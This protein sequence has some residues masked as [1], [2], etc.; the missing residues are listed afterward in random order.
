VPRGTFAHWIRND[1]RAWN[2]PRGTLAGRR[3]CDLGPGGEFTLQCLIGQVRQREAVHA[4]PSTGAGWSR[5]DA[6]ILSLGNSAL[7][8][9][10]T[11]HERSADGNFVGPCASKPRTR[12]RGILAR[13]LAGHLDL[14][15]P[16]A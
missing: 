1:F 13:A 4:S 14:E 11:P 10:G 7:T 16:Q 12:S 5:A 8:D 3:G 6:W 9:A 2:V 15:L